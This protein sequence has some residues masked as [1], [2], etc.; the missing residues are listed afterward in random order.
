M[1]PTPR[2]RQLRHANGRRVQNL[3]FSDDALDY[4]N[5]LA[6]RWELSLSGVLT[7]LLHEQ[8]LREDPPRHVPFVLAARKG[9][10]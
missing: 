6:D 8:G 4:L 10:S 5:V 2:R 3:S 9:A 7:R 1:S